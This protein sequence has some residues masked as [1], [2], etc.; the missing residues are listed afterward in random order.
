MTIRIDADLFKGNL[1]LLQCKYGI[2]QT[3][4]ADKLGVTQGYLSQVINGHSEASI[5]VAIRL[6]MHLGV[7]A[8]HMIIQESLH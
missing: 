1:T 4:A 3:Q 8:S 2:N 7:D 5:E 6:C